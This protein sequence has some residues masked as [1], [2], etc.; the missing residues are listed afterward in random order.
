[1]RAQQ[2]RFDGSCLSLLASQNS[3]SVSQL[4]HDDAVA[5]L[6]PLVQHLDLVVVV[7]VD[8][9]RVAHLLHLQEPKCISEVEEGL[10]NTLTTER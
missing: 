10:L 7:A 4:W 3:G 8:E 5:T 1:M 9:K 2:L 6:L